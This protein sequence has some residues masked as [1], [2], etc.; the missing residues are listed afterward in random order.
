MVT[1]PHKDF[2]HACCAKNFQPLM[3]ETLWRRLEPHEDV[4]RFATM[5]LPKDGCNVTYMVEDNLVTAGL[6][7]SYSL[8]H[9]VCGIMR[10]KKCVGSQLWHLRT[11]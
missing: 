6:L 5:L 3:A 4:L 8:C 11:P 7:L 1:S 10:P 9:E 2:V